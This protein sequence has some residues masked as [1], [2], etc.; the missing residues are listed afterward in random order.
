MSVVSWILLILFLLVAGSAIV[1]LI[2]GLFIE[3][4]N[5]NVIPAAFICALSSICLAFF[6]MISLGFDR[7]QKKYNELSCESYSVKKVITTVEPSSA[8]PDVKADTTYIIRYI[9]KR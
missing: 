9:P 3:Y 1:I 6:L 4:P 5:D 2:V 8:D 7:S